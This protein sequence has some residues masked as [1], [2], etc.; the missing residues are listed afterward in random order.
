MDALATG[1]E[2][3][4]ENVQPRAVG[5]DAEI[6][7]HT[8]NERARDPTSAS[9]PGVESHSDFVA[10]IDKALGTLDDPIQLYIERID[11]LHIFSTEVAKTL[12]KKTL[13]DGTLR[14][15]QNPVYENNVKYLRLWLEFAKLA[16]DPVLVFKYIAQKRIASKLALFYEEY[17]KL[18]CSK[19]W[20]R[21]ARDVFLFGLQENAQPSQRL[22]S[23]FDVFLQ[24]Y[25][26]IQASPSEPDEAPLP[27]PTRQVL[28]HRRPAPYA[29]SA[30]LVPHK[31]L[32]IY[33][34][35]D[36][37]DENVE[38]IDR[39]GPINEAALATLL[40]PAK[41]NNMSAQPWVN[42]TIPQ[43]IS[44]RPRKIMK[45]WCDGRQQVSP[46][47]VL[48]SSRNERWMVD[49]PALTRPDGPRSFSEIMILNRGIT[50]KEPR[51]TW[52]EEQKRQEMAAKIEERAA[53]PI[54]EA[55]GENTQQF[56]GFNGNQSNTEWDPRRQNTQINTFN[57]TL[58]AQFG[59][60]Y[61]PTVGGN[62]KWMS[63]PV[64]PN[65]IE[66]AKER[67]RQA[68]IARQQRMQQQYAQQM[69]ATQV[70]QDARYRQQMSN[71]RWGQKPD[72]Y[73]GQI[74]SPASDNSLTASPNIPNAMTT[75]VEFKPLPPGFVLQTVPINIPNLPEVIDAT[76]E[77]L[78][79]MMRGQ[80]TQVLESVPFYHHENSVK[81]LLPALPKKAAKNS[82]NVDVDIS[83]MRLHLQRLLGVG[84]FGCVY[85]AQVGQLAGYAVKI[86]KGG[87][88]WELYNVLAART[89]IEDPRVLSSLVE[90]VHYQGYT[91]EQYTIMPHYTR[92]TLLKVTEVVHNS[93]PAPKELERLAAYF[94]IELLRLIN[95]LH[96]VD[97]IHGDLKPENVMLRT[98]TGGVKA[99]GNYMRSS[100][101]WDQHGIVLLDFGRAI[102]L[103]LFP[104]G[105]K[106]GA[107]WNPD[108]QQDCW[109]ICRGQPYTFETDYHGIANIVYRILA[110]RPLVVTLDHKGRKVPQHGLPE[111]R[112]AMNV[113]MWMSFF[114][115]MLNP[116]SLPNRCL[117]DV[118]TDLEN[119]LVENSNNGKTPLT[120]L[121]GRLSS[122]K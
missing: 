83:G 20:I 118:K 61:N 47:E 117:Q 84:G 113:D 64:Q 75:K 110:L 28:A 112:D 122:I 109:E 35:D 93:E 11:A 59:T 34:E 85:R 7:A 78:R 48:P 5:H 52:Y 80:L 96:D 36:S 90:V 77:K 76:N 100:K 42:Q 49:I 27:S 51:D 111:C 94:A 31:K 72:P 101:V 50:V 60:S 44:P 95:A 71:Q 91:D 24:K 81:N 114:D 16:S 12:L 87:I 3:Q 105:Q 58:G 115:A 30:I 120:V 54:A 38:N 29:P 45:V 8:L 9:N 107:G 99:V 70:A 23:S 89:R 32:Q 79:L 108:K 73:M 41:E 121:L 46:Y 40:E 39:N 98:P 97:I 67:E 63:S 106:F 43:D 56:M 1:L 68:I 13:V 21:H 6:L 116:P 69:K 10:R 33:V 26:D 66:L 103:R 92:G 53:K 82:V 15:R 4:K 25:G 22:Q 62:T 102:D 2:Q 86:E 65:H 104:P 55:V 119:W 17:A 88:P 37:E 19:N 14:F 74:S 18:L 57:G